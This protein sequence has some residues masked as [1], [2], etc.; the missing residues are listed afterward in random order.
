MSRVMPFSKK[1]E[2]TLYNPDWLRQRYVEEGR[3]A[4]QVAV[5]AK[6]DRGAVLNALRRF[7]IPLKSSAEVIRTRKPSGSSHADRPRAAF[8]DTIHNRAWLEERY[9]VRGMSGT[10]I[11]AEAGCSVTSA[12]REI[13]R[14]FDLNYA[15]NPS[16]RTPERLEGAR[17]RGKARR[18]HYVNRKPCKVCQDPKSTLNHV[19]GN[20]HN[21]AEDNVEWLC[22]KHHLMLD[23]RLAFR[24]AKWMQIN[25]RGT[26]LRWHDEMLSALELRPEPDPR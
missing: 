16:E 13:K 4:A 21:N 17:A 2:H 5:L 6:C 20:P 19:D 26:W 10:Q 23:K 3:N 18:L 1:F 15:R 11:A 9:L 8:K 25:H 7:G 24:A 22:L 12:C 14:Q